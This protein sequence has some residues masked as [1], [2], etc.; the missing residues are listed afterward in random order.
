MTTKKDVEAAF[1]HGLAMW[2]KWAD[3]PHPSWKEPEFSA[4]HTASIEARAAV[5]AIQAGDIGATAVHC[6]LCGYWQGESVPQFLAWRK[7]RAMLRGKLR[8]QQ[9]I[10]EAVKRAAVKKY[11]SLA[12]QYRESWRVKTWWKGNERSLPPVPHK[13]QRTIRGEEKLSASLDAK[14]PSCMITGVDSVQLVN[15]K[16]F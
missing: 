8:E 12:A 4:C 16:V 2:A 3:N 5:A 15:M 6:Y 14:K 11:N 7:V 10:P 13:I 9:I 1:V